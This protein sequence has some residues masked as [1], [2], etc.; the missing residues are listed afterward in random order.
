MKWMGNINTKRWIEKSRICWAG[1]VRLTVLSCLPFILINKNPPKKV[2]VVE[3]KE[4][5]RTRS[6]A[7]SFVA[8]WRRALLYGWD[9]ISWA[10]GFCCFSQPAESV[11]ARPSSKTGSKRETL[12]FSLSWASPLFCYH[13]C[14]RTCVCYLLPIAEWR[15]KFKKGGKRKERLE[16]KNPLF[17]DFWKKKRRKKNNIYLHPINKL[18]YVLGSFVVTFK[19]FPPHWVAFVTCCWE[20][21]RTM[22]P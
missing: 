15:R 2:L 1:S 10:R 5:Q 13:L 6:A 9:E 12:S 18:S 8:W 14:V 4:G 21:V 16:K 7:S 20:R 17:T 11:E 3:R 22:S 19:S